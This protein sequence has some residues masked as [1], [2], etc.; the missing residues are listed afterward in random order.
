VLFDVKL[1]KLLEV[2]TCASGNQPFVVANQCPEGIE[3]PILLV[4]GRD[5]YVGRDGRAPD[6]EENLA[7][8]DSPVVRAR[9][10]RE[11]RHSLERRPAPSR[12]GVF[13]NV[14]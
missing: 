9:T 12:A 7:G 3:S 6:N 2:G 11:A 10:G 14:R 4:G 5:G 8:P 13:R 1:A